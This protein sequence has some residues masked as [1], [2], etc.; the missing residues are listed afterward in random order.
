MPTP[1]QEKTYNE[2][3]KFYDLAEEL[4]SI[5]ENS[6]EKYS[7]LQFK[8]IEKEVLYLEEST[9]KLT[10]NYI[11]IVKNSSDAKKIEE[12]RQLLNDIQ[13][14]TRNCREKLIKLYEDNN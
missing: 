1:N 8:E 14:K 4:I 6:A 3:M 2:F 13:T 10:E 11:C 7:S 12:I 9:D 5:A